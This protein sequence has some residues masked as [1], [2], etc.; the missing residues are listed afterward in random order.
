MGKYDSYSA[1][2][3]SKT[4]RKCSMYLGV[5]VA[6]NILSQTFENVQHMPSCHPGYDFICK[7]DKKINVKSSCRGT[8]NAWV[9]S[10]HKNDICDY[11]LCIAF[12]NRKSLIIK[13]IWLIP[14]SEYRNKNTLYVSENTM[15]KLAEWSKPIENAQKLVDQFMKESNQDVDISAPPLQFLDIVGNPPV[16]KI[17]DF[18]IRNIP[19]NYNK[20][21]VATALGM[22]RKTTYYAWDIL[23]RSH[24]LKTISSDKRAR[25]YVLDKEYPL[26]KALLKL[27]ATTAMFQGESN[28][29]HE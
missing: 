9:F 2:S 4:N 16:V 28:G 8:S 12:E 6:E 5:T 13:G 27:Y 21:Q 17:I 26:T 3:N 7:H 11:F 20:S 22:S 1:R 24:I 25:F 15:H 18:F 19:N 23:D 10:L 14:S 29:L